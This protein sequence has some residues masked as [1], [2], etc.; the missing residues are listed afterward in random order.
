VVSTAL[1]NN[2]SVNS[3]LDHIFRAE[4]ITSAINSLIAPELHSSGISTLKSLATAPDPVGHYVRNWPSV[5]SGISLIINRRTKPH[6]DQ[7]G[8]TSCYD[9]LMTAGNYTDCHIELEELKLMIEYLPGGIVA[10]C[11]KVFKH[12]VQSWNG[13]DRICIAHYFRKNVFYR[14]KTKIPGYVEMS[15]YTNLMN[16]MY[17]QMVQTG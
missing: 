12:A 16:P 8:I 10:I 1:R 4:Q 15:Y 17:S 2:N 6:K 7:H 5:A 13:G 3:F 14:A 9:L 11:G